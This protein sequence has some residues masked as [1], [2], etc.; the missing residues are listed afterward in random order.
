MIPNASIKMILEENDLTMYPTYIKNKIKFHLR[1]RDARLQADG[2]KISFQETYE[3]ECRMIMD[4]LGRFY[5]CIPFYVPACD[6]Q[7]SNHKRDSWA[8]LD[9]GV[10]TFQTIYS[11]TNGIAYKI[12][13]KDISRIYRL[14][15]H[16]DRLISRHASVLIKK[17]R[18]KRAME[19]IRLRIG[20]LVDEVHWKAIHFLVNNFQNII[21][22]PFQ[23]QNMVSKKGVTRKIRAKT[24]RQMLGWSHY[25]F[26]MRLMQKAPLHGSKV[27]VCGEEYTSK[28][29]T[30]CMKIH[31]TLGGQKIFKCPHCGIKVDRDLVGSRNIFMKN[32][33][34][35]TKS[36]YSQQAV[37]IASLEPMSM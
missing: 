27:Y 1:P 24:V 36:V 2:R 31:H 34:V 32:V 37:N 25:R 19:R 35:D 9:P 33:L 7:T 10:R 6:N 11:P 8:S 23:V 22:P 4:K 18:A 17:K 5:L 14:C 12:G 20:H 16:L 26:R 29:C 28:T 21:I 15:I 13:D 3:Y 30:S